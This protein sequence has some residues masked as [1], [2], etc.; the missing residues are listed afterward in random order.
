MQNSTISSQN[1]VIFPH[2]SSKNS[3]K[4]NSTEQF[5]KQ[6]ESK[7]I[8]PS[9]NIYFNRDTHTPIQNNTTPASRPRHL[10]LEDEIFLN[11]VTRSNQKNNVFIPRNGRIIKVNLKLSF[12]SSET[13]VND[14][15]SGKQKADRHIWCRPK[16]NT[17]PHPTYL[18][19]PKHFKYCALPEHHEK[20]AT[21]EK[22][23]N[24]SLLISAYF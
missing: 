8:L 10:D 7:K 18:T 14:L 17:Y 1:M 15:S 2:S 24:S 5:L 3:Q 4:F 6:T 22:K 21:E 12:V 16:I 20:K 23:N 11:H 9:N 13:Q 19:H